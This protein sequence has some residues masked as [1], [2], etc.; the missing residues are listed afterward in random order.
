MFVFVFTLETWWCQPPTLVTPQLLFTCSYRGALCVSAFIQYPCP[1]RRR[2]GKIPLG[3]MHRLG[4][5]IGS[6]VSCWMFGVVPWFIQQPPLRVTVGLCVTIA[7]KRHL[8]EAAAVSAVGEL[9]TLL[10]LA[11][12]EAAVMSPKSAAA[13]APQSGWSGVRCGWLGFSESL[14]ENVFCSLF[15]QSCIIHDWHEYVAA[16]VL[17][18]NEVTLRTNKD[19]THS[20]INSAHIGLG[21][22]I[23][24]RGGN[25]KPG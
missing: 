14:T 20:P 5:Q 9:T 4:L 3:N 19:I 7:G 24:E 15:F 11:L 25:P 12:S 16:E 13:V 1:H 22:S 8:S 6:R 10:V 21:P 23:I 18:Q 17:V 2:M